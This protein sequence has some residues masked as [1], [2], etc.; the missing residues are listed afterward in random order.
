M[1]NNLV[2]EKTQALVTA[3]SSHTF[4]TAI[5][6]ASEQ[7][8]EHREPRVRNVVAELFGELGRFQGVSV[9]LFLKERLLNSILTNFEREGMEVSSE[10]KV[11]LAEGGVVAE[12]GPADAGSD[13]AHDASHSH[14]AERGLTIINDPAGKPT[15]AHD[16]VGWKVHSTHSTHSTA[17]STAQNTSLSSSRAPQR[18]HR[19]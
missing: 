15:I 13:A 10:Q 8:L 18:T 3:L 6:T 11:V 9:Y 16:T 12:V 17:H 4:V 5:L 1:A 7:E 14:E 19:L 2:P